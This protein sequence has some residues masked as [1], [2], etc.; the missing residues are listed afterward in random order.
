MQT[1]IL[2]GGLGTRLREETEYRPKPMVKI[3]TRPILWHIMMIYAKY[4]YK[5]FVLPLGYKGDMI[6]EYFLNYK[7][8]NSDIT[9]DFSNRCDVIFHNEN[10]DIDWKVTMV[11]TGES[12]LKGGRIKLVEK[13]ITENTFMLT[14]G[15]GVAGIEIDKLVA[16]HKSHGR[17]ATV[18]GVNIASRY[19][20][21]HVSGDCVTSFVEKPEIY[22]R[23]LISGGFFVFNREIFDYL[24]VSSDSDLEYGALERVAQEGQLMVYRHD[25]FW[26]CMDTLRDVELLNALWKQANAPWKIW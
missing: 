8:I 2:C 16:F 11:D 25:G 21:L 4:G 22:D 1:I 18:T 3:G 7:Y 13:Y 12:T 24:S 26:Y 15:D 10:A 14:Y 5:H 9:L 20:E 6:R 23:G 17:I 19:G